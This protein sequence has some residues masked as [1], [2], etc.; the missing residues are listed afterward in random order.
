MIDGVA[1]AMNPWSGINVTNLNFKNKDFSFPDPGGW[2]NSVNSSVDGLSTWY[3]AR[4]STN[5]FTEIYNL[6]RGVN[7]SSVTTN[8][9]TGF[10]QMG[11]RGGPNSYDTLTNSAS[12]GLYPAVMINMDSG[13]IINE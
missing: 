8:G 7:P 11:E 9:L 1:V 2:G 6:G 5:E 12:G 10:Y 4:P 13:A 3:S